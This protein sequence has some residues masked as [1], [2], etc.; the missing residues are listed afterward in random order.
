MVLVV[1]SVDFIHQIRG[2]GHVWG[3][4]AQTS[5]DSFFCSK[6]AILSSGQIV[7]SNNS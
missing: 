6:A 1:A 2:S 4:Y 5:R 7:P 3:I